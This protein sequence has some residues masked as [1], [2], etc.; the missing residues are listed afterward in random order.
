MRWLSVLNLNVTMIVATREARVWTALTISYRPRTSA[1]VRILFFN[2]KS[3]RGKNRIKT[4]VL[5]I[6]QHS[7]IKEVNA[8]TLDGSW[9]RTWSAY[10][11]VFILCRKHIFIPQQIQEYQ[12]F[13]KKFVKLNKHSSSIIHKVNLISY[14]KSIWK[15]S[16]RSLNSYT[17]K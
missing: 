14:E 13:T 5:C 9:K 7:A 1:P 15:F 4:P 2:K 10:F 16:H 11:W 3:A 17:N 8:H 12:R 6:L